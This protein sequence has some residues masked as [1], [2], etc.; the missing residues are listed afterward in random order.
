MQADP[1]AELRSWEAATRAQTDFVRARTSDVALGTDPYVI[2]RI[3]NGEGAAAE[4]RFVGILRGRSALVE[5]DDALREVRRFAAPA[6]PTGLA[7]AA[8]GDVFAVG[9]LS[10]RVARFRFASGR[11]EPAGFIEL[12]GV[13]AIRDVAT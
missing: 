5:L 4:D 12:P 6:S 8:S 10:S 1:L 9:E 3:S 7:V 11:L 2:R 13:R